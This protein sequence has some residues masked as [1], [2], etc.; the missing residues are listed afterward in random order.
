MIRKLLPIAALAALS[1]CGKADG[2][3]NAGNWKTT[4]KITSFEIPGAPA[5]MQ[6]AMHERM[7]L[8]MT[9]GQSM[10][11]CMTEAQAKAGVRDFSKNA[12][13]GDCTLDPYEQ[14]G[15]KMSGTLKCKAGM[16]GADGMKMDGT[17]TADK[18]DMNMAADI[19]QPS[20]PGGKATIKM[21]VVSERTGDCAK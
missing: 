12:Q 20:L 9:Q 16:F 10:E 13:Q 19:Q 3:L 11:M 21:N 17:Y 8:M 4:M 18:V 5:E 6:A 15:G 14:G 2:E 7:K 1:A